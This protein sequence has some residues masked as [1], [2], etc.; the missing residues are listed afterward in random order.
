[1]KKKLIALSGVALMPFLALAQT[2]T[3]G[4]VANCSSYV[5]QTNLNSLLCKFSEL[6]NAAIPVLI[7][8]GVI[9]FIWGVVTYFIA[10]DEE[11][12]SA[13][14]NRIFLGIIGLVVIVGMW[15]LVRIVAN[16]FG[17][18]NTSTINLPTVQY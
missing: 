14:R 12:K 8:L 1:M 9:Y 5:G 2:T 18:N 11:A 13:G 3:G 16:T 17:L 15:G 6:L 10:S 4:S 7:A